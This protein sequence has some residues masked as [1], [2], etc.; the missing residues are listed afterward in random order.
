MTNFVTHISALCTNMSSDFKYVFQCSASFLVSILMPFLSEGP[1]TP[2]GA[3]RPLFRFRSIPPLRFCT[4][5]DVR[6]VNQKLP[7]P[8]LLRATYRVGPSVFHLMSPI[9]RVTIFV[10]VVSN[11]ATASQVFFSQSY[12]SNHG[13]A[14]FAAGTVSIKVQTGSSKPDSDVRM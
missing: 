10:M 14:V 1:L 7:S 12:F 8:T 9:S 2:F 13:I 3:L 11:S 5:K 6:D 4:D